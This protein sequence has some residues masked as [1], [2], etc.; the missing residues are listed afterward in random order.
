[1]AEENNNV[2]QAVAITDEQVNQLTFATITK[3]V[4]SQLTK[5]QKQSLKARLTPEEWSKLGDKFGGSNVVP[6][7]EKVA[8]N[9]PSPVGPIV[10]PKI[11][12]VSPEALKKDIVG[13]EPTEQVGDITFED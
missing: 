8:S 13:E 4:F 5:D 1:M 6:D 7:E 11:D 2:A 9:S 10:F 12:F 3:E